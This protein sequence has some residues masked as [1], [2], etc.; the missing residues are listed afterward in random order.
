MKVKT[1]VY[2]YTKGKKEIVLISNMHVGSHNYFESIKNISE[3]CEY[4]LYEG[5]KGKNDVNLNEAYKILAECLGSI[6]QRDLLLYMRSKD[7]G[8]YI[9]ADC[10]IEDVE[11]FKNM[12]IA[13][14]K[15]RVQNLIDNKGSM[16]PIL[17]KISF[18]IKLIMNLNILKNLLISSKEDVVLKRNKIVLEELRKINSYSIA[19][20]YGVGH[21]KGI[22]DG[23]LGL[24]YKFKSKKKLIAIA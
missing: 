21:Y 18:F 22:R 20:I 2:T 5:V 8:K 19:I 12:G 7:S 6:T 14:D 15:D 3:R 9:N 16:M 13:N 10:H 4:I 23:I 24:G 11:E 17:K 1:P